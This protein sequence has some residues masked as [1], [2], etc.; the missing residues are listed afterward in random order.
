MQNLEVDDQGDVPKKY[1][2]NLWQ[3]RER[4]QKIYLNNGKLF[5]DLVHVRN[6]TTQ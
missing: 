4:L 5:N 1:P 6:K 2:T 3:A